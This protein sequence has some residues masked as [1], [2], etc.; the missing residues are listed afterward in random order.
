MVANGLISLV[1]LVGA[2]II[3]KRPNNGQPK[4]PSTA[5]DQSLALVRP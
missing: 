4:L 5:E 3:F 1:T 2:G